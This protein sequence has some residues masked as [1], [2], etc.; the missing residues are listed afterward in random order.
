VRIVRLIRLIRIVKIYKNITNES[1]DAEIGGE[2]EYDEIT[3][4]KI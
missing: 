1:V 3:G 4:A 2:K